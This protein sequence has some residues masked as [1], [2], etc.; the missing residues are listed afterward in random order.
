MLVFFLVQ[1]G[2]GQEVELQEAGWVDG[3]DGLDGRRL[4]CRRLDGWRLIVK[5]K[6]EVLLKVVHC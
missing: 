2:K 6:A 1:A 3:L 4:N 5:N